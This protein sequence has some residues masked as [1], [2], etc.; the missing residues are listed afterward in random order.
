MT[1]QPNYEP[2]ATSRA[3]AKELWDMHQ[4]LVQAGFSEAQALHII[5]AAVAA[6]A[7]SGRDTP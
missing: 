4:A 6:A 3:L 7:A 1:A 5:G 2:S